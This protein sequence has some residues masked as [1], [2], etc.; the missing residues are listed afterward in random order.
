MATLPDSNVQRF[1]EASWHAYIMDITKTL[2]PDV[3]KS[4][5]HAADEAGAMQGTMLL[6]EI[7][8]HFCVGERDEL[9]ELAREALKKKR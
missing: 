7:L 2:P 4:V 5:R 9:A 1:D 6:L 8:R 3:A